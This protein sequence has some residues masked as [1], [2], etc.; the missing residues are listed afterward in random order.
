[1]G[2]ATLFTPPKRGR[3]KYARRSL[4]NRPIADR[5]GQPTSTIAGLRARGNS[6]QQARLS[7]LLFQP[8]TFRFMGLVFSIA[9]AILL[10]AV[11]VIAAP[12][13]VAFLL[14]IGKEFLTMLTQLFEILSWLFG[15]E[16]RR[17]A[18]QQMKAMA[19]M[20]TWLITAPVAIPV[21]WLRKNTPAARR[22]QQRNAKFDES[23][24]R[25]FLA[26]LNEASIEEERLNK[27]A[28]SNLTWSWDK[29]KKKR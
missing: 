23:I 29:K 1:M 22:Q 16:A 20:F 9:A 25:Q 24:S 10:A 13:V 6:G 19:R 27:E 28:S 3:V 15:K 2:A 18:M 21:R 4:F 14:L 8:F 26:A 11:I 7:F 5:I 12:F 17:E